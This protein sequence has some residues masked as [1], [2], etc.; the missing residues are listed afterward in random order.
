MNKLC[1]CALC[2]LLLAACRPFSSLFG[3]WENDDRV[4]TFNSYGTFE[5]HNKNALQVKAFRGT[6]LQKKDILVLLFEEYETAEDGW[7]STSGT[8][9]E[10][11]KEVLK[12][13]IRDDQLTTKILATGKEF[14]YKRTFPE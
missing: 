7:C 12:V 14:T 2:L 9:L 11:Y 4:L 6:M 13:S 1:I 5:I 8:D 10:D 3:S